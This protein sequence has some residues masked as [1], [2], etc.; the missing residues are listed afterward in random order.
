LKGLI[1]AF[2]SHNEQIEYTHTKVILA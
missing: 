2:Q 1:K